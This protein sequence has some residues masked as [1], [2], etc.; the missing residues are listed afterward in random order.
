MSTRVAL[1]GVN[2]HGRWHLDNIARL[3]ATGSVTLAAACD[4]APVQADSGRILDALDAPLFTSYE[5]LLDATQPAVVVLVTPPATH[6]PLATQAM[7]A[8]ADVLVEK[9]ATVRL[10]ELDTLIETAGRLGR[11]CQIGFQSSGS[12]AP[13]RIAET[14]AA[15]TLGPLRQVYAAGAWS[16]PPAY[17]RRAPWAGRR[18]LNGAAVGDGALA[19]PFA[20]ALMNCL[21]IAG[22]TGEAVAGFETELYHANDIESDDTSSVRLR[23]DGLTVNLAV[24]LAAD[25]LVEPYL[26]AAG[27]H[28]ALRWQYTTDELWLDRDGTAIQDGTAI[29]VDLPPARDLLPDLLDARA[30][31][32]EPLCP[33]RH[34]RAFTALSERLLD[35][36]EPAPIGASHLTGT[37]PVTVAGVTD[38]VVRAAAAGELFSEAG[39]TWA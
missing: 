9:P 23:R 30:S 21:R 3:A 36:P 24:T 25:R 26:V 2:G 8:G 10:D 11:L 34:C 39:A 33:P 37:D 16:R 12:Y 28:G 13:E 17:F 1:V 32:R 5:K 22:V 19:N 6:L 27:E 38:L 7:A 35:G 29:R 14:F 31:G 15:G 4:L 20:H 18:F